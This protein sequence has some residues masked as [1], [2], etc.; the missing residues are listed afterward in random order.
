[1]AMKYNQGLFNPINPNK[2]KGNSKNIIYRSGWECKLM[3]EL[4]KNPNVLEWASEE[5]CIPYISPIDGKRHRY[6]PDFWV[7]KKNH[8][9]GKIV[10]VVIEIKPKSQTVAPKPIVGKKPTKR[11]LNEVYTWGVNSAKWE[12]AERFCKANNLEFIIMTEADLGIK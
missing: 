9:D 1:M 3:M 7:K 2:Y 8:S 6:Y 5:F 11:Y 10:E 12:A 4:D